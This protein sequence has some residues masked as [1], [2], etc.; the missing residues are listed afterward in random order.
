MYNP[1]AILPC[2]GA[3]G[4]IWGPQSSVKSVGTN[5]GEGVPC[6]FCLYLLSSMPSDLENPFSYTHDPV[7]YEEGLKP[8]ENI[9]HF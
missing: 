8:Q 9:P 4:F 3:L 1:W 6:Y 5:D 7:P 2:C